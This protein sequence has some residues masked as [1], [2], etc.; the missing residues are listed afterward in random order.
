M[1]AGQVLEHPLFRPVPHDGG[2]HSHP[3]VLR[4]GGGGGGLPG[5]L[6]SCANRCGNLLRF[7][8]QLNDE[9]NGLCKVVRGSEKATNS[10]LC[11]SKGW[12]RSWSRRRAKRRG[13][14][15]WRWRREK[16][17]LTWG[18]RCSICDDNENLW[19][20][21]TDLTSQYWKTQVA[22]DSYSNKASPATVNS[23]G[24]AFQVIQNFP[25]DPKLS[26]KLNNYLYNS[27]V[28]FA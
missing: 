15:C 6:P 21:E 18:S 10:K 4:V 23:D 7:Q 28:S 12:L 2:A 5:A 25:G 22:I 19:A 16:L 3:Q 27:L 20:A 9:G 1:N 17:A 24:N 14:R 11:C 8:L 13:W 26:Q